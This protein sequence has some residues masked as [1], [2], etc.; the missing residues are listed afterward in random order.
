MSKCWLP[1]L[2]SKLSPLTSSSM[3]FNMWKWWQFF[4]TCSG[5]LHHDCI[6]LI[7]YRAEDFEN[8]KYCFKF[9]V[10]LGSL[11]SDIPWEN[12]NH[13]IRGVSTGDR[14]LCQKAR[15]F[16]NCMDTESKLKITSVRNWQCSNCMEMV[17]VWRPF[18]QG[19]ELGAFAKHNQYCLAIKI[20]WSGTILYLQ[21]T[22][23]TQ[24]QRVVMWHQVGRG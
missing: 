5:S 10:Q 4:T 18:I 1:W 17:P 6:F 2:L 22:C 11:T 9:N 23:S 8:R 19:L 16:L 20:S 24:I 14:K 15:C 7:Q 3:L 13:C 12:C 21:Y